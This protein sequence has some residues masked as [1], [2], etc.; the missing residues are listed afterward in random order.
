LIE[1]IAHRGLHK[2]VPENTLEA[3]RQAL[4]AGADAVEL[5]VHAT[6][7]GIVVVHHDPTVSGTAEDPRLQSIPTG[8]LSIAELSGF[9]VGGGARVPRLEEVLHLVRGRA[10]GYVEIKGWGIEELVIACVRASGADCAIHSFNHRSIMRV[11][12]LAPEIPRGL[13]EETRP[14]DPVAVLAAAGARDLWP[15]QSVADEQLVRAVHAH[16]GRV[17]AWTA[18]DAADWL[19]L[20]AA[21]VDAICTNRVG[22]FVAWR[23]SGTA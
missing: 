11:R 2:S 15:Y 8:E 3:F 19:R 4:E 22:D 16:G 5:D 13:L 17:I 18:D 12:D 14:P 6:A 9:D 23:D 21:G 1:A 7:D 10:R 20:R